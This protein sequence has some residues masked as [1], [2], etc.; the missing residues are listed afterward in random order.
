MT[1]TTVLSM[2]DLERVINNS[3][4]DDPYRKFLLVHFAR[5]ILDG[6]CPDLH[7]NS[8][9]SK[10]TLEELCATVAREAAARNGRKI[11][12]RDQGIKP[13]GFLGFGSVPQST[14][15][16][17]SSVNNN[18]PQGSLFASPPTK[19]QNPW[20]HD[21]NKLPQQSSGLFSLANV[22]AANSFGSHTN[23][24]GRHGL[25]GDDLNRQSLS[26]NAGLFD[27]STSISN[28]AQASGLF[29][30]LK[31]G[32][33]SGGGLFDNSPKYTG[34]LFSNVNN[35]P[36][37]GLFGP[38]QRSCFSSGTSGG[39]FGNAS[40]VNT[41]S[42]LFGSTS[43]HA[44]S[45]GIFG[46]NSTSPQP[47]GLFGSANVN[48]NP[49]R[50]LFGTSSTTSHGGLFGSNNQPTGSLFGNSSN[51]P[52]SGG[53]FGN[54]NVY[55]RPSGG[56]FGNTISGG[57]TGGSLFGHTGANNAGSLFGSNLI[58]SAVPQSITHINVYGQGI[59]RHPITT[60]HNQVVEIPFTT[61]ITS[62]VPI[63]EKD[64]I[65]ANVSSYQSISYQ[66]GYVRFSPEELR[67]ADYAGG[68]SAIPYG[69]FLTGQALSAAAQDSALWK[70]R[71]EDVYG[72]GSTVQ[73]RP[74]EH[75]DM[76]NIR[77]LA[78]S[79]NDLSARVGE[80]SEVLAKMEA[81]DSQS[82][83][84]RLNKDT[85]ESINI[86]EIK[87][88]ETLSLDGSKAGA[89]P[90]TATAPASGMSTPEIILTP[91]TSRAESTDTIAAI[92]AASSIP[93]FQFPVRHQ[94]D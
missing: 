16:F 81:D 68:V 69:Q 65:G 87:S 10:T 70:P 7:Q 33:T 12:Q 35:R 28:T 55:S 48:N 19:T 56:L 85:Q 80:M 51:K 66:P 27:N 84:S 83:T 36:T 30:N 42:G 1:N 32:Q 9:I 91:T 18:K 46:N 54:I 57:M 77:D 63:E 76:V 53:L 26:S 3:A 67:Y 94:D 39:I 37:S 45:G 23:N 40:G 38:V 29:G 4:T 15:L 41:G 8:E 78:Q 52:S 82:K 62:L 2:T 43:N 72:Q 50:S 92:S 89:T 75:Q 58:N 49:S 88:T 74:L 90:M 20:D 61:N 5:K 11:E 6:D 60:V 25:Q 44:S 64:P 71:V 93:I 86:Q 21:F 14:S 31:S 34:G 22:N 73:Q 59:N 79:I 13:V 47:G 24:N 17:S